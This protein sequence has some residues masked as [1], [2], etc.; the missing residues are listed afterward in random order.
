MLKKVILSMLILVMVVSVTA[1]AADYPRIRVDGEFVVIPYYDQQPVIVDGRTLVPLRAV[2]EALGFRVEWEQ[3][4]LNRATL[5]KPG[6]NVTVTIGRDTMFVNGSN[7]PLDVPA[8]IMNDRTMVPLRAISEATGMRVEWDSK[9]RIADI[10]TTNY[11]V[12]RSSIV[13]TNERITDQQLAEWKAEY[14]EL[15]SANDFEIEVVRLINVERANHGLSPLEMY[16]PLMMAARFKSQEMYDLNY[17]AHD[18]PVYGSFNG[19]VRLF[20]TEAR[21]ENL[22]RR[23]TAE[24]AVTSWMNSPGHRAN[25]LREDITIIGIGQISNLVTMQV[26]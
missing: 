24:E 19:I 10:W 12:T 6:F 21:A 3:A 16:E 18:S 13:L 9:N 5:T 26:R 4:P 15:G 22:T 8:Q 23:S 7:I 17:F 25:V 1:I 20:D 2:M 14:R 11:A